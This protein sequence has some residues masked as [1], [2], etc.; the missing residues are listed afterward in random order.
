MKKQIKIN[1]QLIYL[2]FLMVILL[3]ISI[4]GIKTG[5]DISIQIFGIEVENIDN[6]CAYIEKEEIY[7]S[8]D[9]LRQ[10]IDKD[11]FYNKVS[12]SINITKDGQI[13]RLKVG[14]K[15]ASF[16]YQIINVERVIEKKDDNIYIPVSSIEGIYNIAGINNKGKG[17]YIVASNSEE[18]ILKND[19]INAYS[20]PNITSFLNFKINREDKLQLYYNLLE[21]D[22]VLVKAENGQVGYIQKYNLTKASLEKLNTRQ[23]EL[24]AQIAKDEQINEVSKIN[25]IVSMDSMSVST[26]YKQN[27]IENIFVDMFEILKKDGQVNITGISQNWIDT[28]KNSGYNIYGSI[29][30]GYNSSN[31]DNTV[32]A[33]VIKNEDVRDKLI[34]NI[35][36]EL[37]KYRLDGLIVNFKSIKKEDE[38]IY[39]QFLKELGTAIKRSNKKLFVRGNLDSHNVNI[40][41]AFNYIDYYIL[42]GYNHRNIYSNISGT[43][44]D[45]N[46][47]K[48]DIDDVIKINSVGA[49]SKIILELPIYSI[50]W[51]EKNSKVI[52]SSIYNQK[53]INDYIVKNKLIKKLDGKTNQNYLEMTKGSIVY[54]MWL[55]DEYSLKEKIKLVEDNR[56]A[57]I[58]I[59][60]AGYEINDFIAKIFK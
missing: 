24:K 38:E 19:Y 53:A 25:S 20:R 51:E 36:K 3:G 39:N 41:K 50:L 30:N 45:I 43:D 47:I 49:S 5:K 7:L 8:L 9:I 12:R 1:K 42:V 48:K 13:L 57:G 40:T 26:A 22:W 31:F 54:K 59:Y 32:I 17:I 34:I 6:K 55:E 18:V 46:I 60:R 44:S 37:E 15:K 16:N 11:V 4:T 35:L 2:V 23:I 58:V 10:Y 14:E 28:A 52:N 33:T 29:S 56:L 21:S 27:G